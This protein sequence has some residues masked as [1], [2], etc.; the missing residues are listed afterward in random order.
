VTK[1][2]NIKNNRMRE[3]EKIFDKERGK[4]FNRKLLTKNGFKFCVNYSLL[5]EE[6]IHRIFKGSNFK[7]TVVASGSFSRRELAPYSDVQLLIILPKKNIFEKQAENIVST[8]SNTE[9]NFTVSIKHFDDIE[10]ALKNDLTAFTQFFE[11]R[12]ILG[13]REVYEKW[14]KNLFDSLNDENRRRLIKNYINGIEERHALYGDSPKLLEP[15]LKLS[16]GGLRDIQ[17]VEWMYSLKNGEILTDESEI[18]QTEKFLQRLY[19][20][21]LISGKER[22]R[23]LDSYELLL[24]MRN[25]LHL[26]SRRKNDRLEFHYQKKIAEMLG[27]DKEKWLELMHEFF[28]ATSLI[29]RF[30][31][32]LIKKF[33]EDIEKP[34]SDYLKIDLDED[35]TLK[36]DKICTNRRG[37]LSPS[38]IMRAFYYRGFHGAKFNRHL[39]SL[40]SE[41]INEMEGTLNEELTSSVF[42]REILK[43]P[44]NVADTLS[45]M[46]ELGFL[47]LFL[48]EFGDIV[49][50]FQEGI[51][52]KYTTD[53]HTL[54]AI[55]N[56][57][58]LSKQNSELGRLFELTE[59][60]DLLY[61]ALLLHDIGKPI[62]IEGHE[63]LGAEYAYSIGDRLGYSFE[64]TDLVAFLVRHHLTMANYAFKHPAKDIEAL[65]KFSGIFP[66]L[67]SLNLLYLLTVA[68]LSAANPLVL[69][70]WKK[71]I[72][73][74]LFLRTRVMVEE[75]L[76][77]SE[78]SLIIKKE[79]SYSKGEGQLGE[80]LHRIENPSYFNS[81]TVEEIRKHAEEIE[82]G[83]KVSVLFTQKENFTDITIFTKKEELSLASLCGALT[84]N[85]LNIRTAKIFTRSDGI[86]INNF[87]VTDYRTGGIIDTER[88]QKIE[89]DIALAVDF[90]LEITKEFKKYRSKWKL[91]GDKIFKKKGKISVD[92]EEEGEFTKISVFSP[93]AIGLLYT[94][95]EAFSE[96]NIKI[97]LT[98]LETI[99]KD[100]R[101]Y[102]YVLNNFGQK[103]SEDNYELIKVTLTKRIKEIVEK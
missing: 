63:I 10:E 4:L 25:L 22:K 98:K 19:K 103:I 102:F 12:F 56:L 16:A 47:G 50:F 97:F 17:S 55:R 86:A 3:E 32:T 68:D 30:S 79:S 72:L 53:E 43:L 60:K 31:R 39:R 59:R 2:E 6:F 26:I 81:F 33:R 5:I 101:S 54:L 44:Q 93:D 49:G 1:Q 52:H 8:L 14:N 15:S 67:E 99:D 83:K 48:R 78:N 37:A 73:Q 90:N 82:K 11:T 58:L 100:V 87:E 7:F 38:T 84:L 45:I 69:N 46:N 28:E 89:S 71:G 35:F 96:L 94:I 88:F 80:H 23:V 21:K 36:G 24:R 85:D 41:S 9:I 13:K 64:E 70:S 75:R 42:F 40:I 62:N 66:S 74:K 34:L 91:F 51:Y 20:E 29:N 18:T 95:T 77:R 76:K 92:F 61:L 57:E 65:K 27:Y